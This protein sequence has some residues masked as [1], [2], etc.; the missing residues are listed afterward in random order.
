MKTLFQFLI[1]ILSMSPSWAKAEES[2]AV[3][4]VI[5]QEDG[6]EGNELWASD[7]VFIGRVLDKLNRD[8]FI[9]DKF[10]LE[11]G[12]KR[13]IQNSELYRAPQIQLLRRY[14][15]ERKKGKILVVVSSEK[16]VDSHGLARKQARIYDPVIIMRGAYQDPEN[17]ITNFEGYFGSD[18][19]VMQASG[20]FRH[21]IG[22]QM[23]YFHIPEN[24]AINTDNYAGLPS[25][26]SN[27]EGYFLKL[28]EFQGR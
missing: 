21:E 14:S 20:L 25:E 12:N 9:T 11:L 4:F 5:L 17:P 13:V 26:R 3:D 10:E 28:S 2:V 8:I 15:R 24:P 22:H 27:W 19:H 16:K 23:N 1:L 6:G 7:D 18:L